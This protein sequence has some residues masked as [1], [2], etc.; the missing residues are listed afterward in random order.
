M[1]HRDFNPTFIVIAVLTVLI[2]G[3]GAYYFGKTSSNTQS[4]PQPVIPIV[5]S[6]PTIIPSPV[7]L[8]QAIDIAEGQERQFMVPGGMTFTKPA[9]WRLNV[10]DLSKYRPEE[11]DFEVSLGISVPKVVN[12]EVVSIKRYNYDYK[13]DLVYW[14]NT[15][16]VNNAVGA[17]TGMQPFGKTN[18]PALVVKGKG[19]VAFTVYYVINKSYIFGILVA[20]TDSH[21]NQEAILFVNSIRFQ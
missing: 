16:L 11:H 2:I 17:I 20:D 5:D 21:N 18:I 1:N 8:S 10:I 12:S 3:G 14:Y 6:Q 15:T 7:V 4:K 13:S 19:Q 9:D